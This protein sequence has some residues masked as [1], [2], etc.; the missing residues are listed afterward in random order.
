[1]LFCYNNI[2]YFLYNFSHKK[3]DFVFIENEEDRYTISEFLNTVCATSNMLVENGV[4]RGDVVEILCKKDIETII[5]FCACQVLGCVAFMVGAQDDIDKIEKENNLTIKYRVFENRRIK[6]AKYFPMLQFDDLE[7]TKKTTIMISTSGSTGERKIVKLSQYAFINNA[8]DSTDYGFYEESDIA[9]AFLPMNHVFAIA[10]LFTAICFKF[11][12]FVAK[13][14][15]TLYLLDTIEKYHITRFNAVPSLL[16][17]MVEL[18]H[19]DLSS[20]KCA[21]IGGASCS[22]KEFIKIEKNLGIKLISVYG[23]SE[24][25]GISTGSYQDSSIVLASS[26]GKP[27]PLNEVKL[28]NDGEIMVKGPSM[29]NGY[30][31]SELPT[32]DGY[33]LTGD[34]GEFDAFGNLH[35]IGRKKEIIIR[36]GLNISISE[37]TKK[38]NDAGLF[39]EFTVVGINDKNYGEVP[40]L[41]VVLNRPLNQ[42]DIN[43]EL[44][45]YLKTYEMPAKVLF[46]ESIPQ[47][48]NGKV[49]KES[50][51]K[52]LIR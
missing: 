42:D 8:I 43:I 40:A 23:M 51:K 41:A 48:E 47:L 14:S 37:I 39:K 4:K 22:L 44:S 11:N 5:Y 28:S 17:R 27:Y 38:L 7:D 30:V 15:D 32:E 12:V 33:L 50:V 1:M 25:I 52:M 29:A 21:Y 46:M 36:N 16:H 31:G 49:D 24:C 19:H 2:F 18:N 26:V 20:L 10:M 34:I 13:S 3:P 45:K 9:L 35:V 6:K